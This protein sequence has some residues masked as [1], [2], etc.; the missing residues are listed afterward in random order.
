MR[1]TDTYRASEFD[2]AAE[3]D[4]CFRETKGAF[5]YVFGRFRW[6]TEECKAKLAFAS[7]G[8]ISF[9]FR[10]GAFP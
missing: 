9:V 2:T 3:S 8:A 10:T 1:Q 6:I 5:V 4:E 7:A